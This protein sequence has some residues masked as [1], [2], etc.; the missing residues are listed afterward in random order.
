L[1][2][3]MLKQ[4]GFQ[5][6]DEEAKARRGRAQRN[7]LKEVPARPRTK[8]PHE[9]GVATGGAG[10]EAQTWAVLEAMLAKLKTAKEKGNETETRRWRVAIIRQAA[11]RQEGQAMAFASVARDADSGSEDGPREGAGENS[12]PGADRV[13]ARYDGKTLHDGSGAEESPGARRVA[14]VDQEVA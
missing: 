5:D 7:I 11:A 8:V 6:K 14:Q 9:G 1:E 3:Q 13:G 12:R 4:R 10:I 2:I